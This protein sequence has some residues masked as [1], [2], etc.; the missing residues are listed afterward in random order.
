[1]LRREL[2]LT[3]SNYS[4]I[5]TQWYP[6]RSKREDVLDYLRRKKIDT[7]SVSDIPATLQLLALM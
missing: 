2:G 6:L 1:M 5:F 7:I 4:T 3:G